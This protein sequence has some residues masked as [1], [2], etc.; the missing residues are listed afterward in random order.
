MSA[1]TTT[2][3]VILSVRNLRVEY[4]DPA[5]AVCAVDNVSLDLCRGE[6]FALA[7]ESGSGKSTLGGAIL[8]VLRAPAVITAGAIWFD[9]RDILALDEAQLRDYR[10]REVAMVFQSAMNTLSPV[11]P[12]EEQIVDTMRAHERG[13]GRVAA[14]DRARQLLELVGLD[15]GHARSYAHELSGGMRQRVVIAIALALSPRLLIM[16]EPTTAL[17]V[18][19]QREI[20]QRIWAIKDELHLSVLF[21]AHDLPLMLEIADRIGVM[22]AAELVEIAPAAELRR[23]PH[24]PYSRGLLQAFPALDRPREQVHEIPGAPPSLRSPP[25]GCRFHPRC[26]DAVTSCRVD[27]PL[28]LPTT[29]NRSSACP[30]PHL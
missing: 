27:H 6:V 8:R 11:L 25:A 21:I 7:G 18:V 17:D 1:A 12:I 20:L 5:G 3:D 13:I 14:R 9:G 2:N 19:V 15:P 4:W 28:L 30:R 16:D 24:H 10:W 22:Y 29:A 23:D 26:P